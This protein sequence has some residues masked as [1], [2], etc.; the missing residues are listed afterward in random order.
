M[1]AS[2]QPTETFSIVVYSENKAGV[3][4]RV[5]T[6]FTRR[7]INIESLTVSESEI[8]GIHR[9]TIVVELTEDMANKVV[10]AIEKQIDVQK[11][12]WYRESEIIYREIAMYKMRAELLSEG[13]PALD[14]VDQNNARIVSAEKEF[15]IVQK[16]GRREATQK[17]FEELKPFG[18]L[19][20]VRSGRIAISKRMKE[21]KDYLAELDVA[22]A[23]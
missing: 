18:I 7:K 8:A 4:H 17:L 11:A 10:A 2:E 9:Y 12:F 13:S 16:T 14:I 23:R 20:F 21:L 19:E 1:N 6:S 22:S 15:A 3:L 5:T